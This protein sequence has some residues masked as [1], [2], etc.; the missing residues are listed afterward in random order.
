MTFNEALEIVLAQDPRYSR[1]AYGFLREVLSV[2]MK[3]H[4]KVKRDLEGH[5]SAAEILET[6]RHHALKEFGPMA[7]TVLSYW[8][9]HGSVDVGNMVFALVDAKFLTK[10]AED[11][12]ESF[13]IGPSFEEI[14]LQPFQPIK[15][16]ER[17]SS[18]GCL[19]HLC[20]RPGD[21]F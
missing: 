12:V 14:F 21:A 8:G 10:N 7:L 11:T 18:T 6:F 17:I 3:R 4:G 20:D 16:N 1:D 15:K 2:T 19:T 5:V 13:Q 9:I